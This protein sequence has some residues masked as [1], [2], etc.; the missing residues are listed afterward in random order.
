M[1]ATKSLLGILT[2]TTAL[3]VQ[4]QAQS[5]LTNGLVAYYPLNGNANDVSGNGNNGYAQNTYST[6]N[7]FGQF[8][9]A[10]GFTGNSWVYIP[11]STSMSTTNF[12]VSLMFNSQTA[13]ATLNSGTFCLLRSGAGQSSSDFYRG[14]EISA[15]DFGQNFGFWDFDGNSDYGPGKCVT[16]ISQWQ[17]NTWYNLIF[18]QNGTNAQFYVNGVLVASATNTVP[19]APAQSSP[20]YI[21]SNSS[22]T[23]DPTATPGGMFTGIIYDVRFYNRA[24]S[25]DEVHQLS[26]HESAT[27]KFELINGSF[28]S[29]DAA[30]ADAIARGGHL[31]TITSAQEWQQFVDTVGADAIT[32]NAWWLGASDI[33][34]QGVWAWIT[35]ETWSYTRWGAGEPSGTGVNGPENYLVLENDGTW[36]DAAGTIQIP[37]GYVLEFEPQGALVKQVNPAFTMLSLGANYQLQVSTDLNTWT[38][39]GG[40]FTATNS[41][42]RSTN[43][44]DV[45]SWNHLYFRLQLAP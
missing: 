15:V 5:F 33:Q 22:G 45:D 9:S 19:Y 12:T 1:K 23:S 27:P 11:Y 2:I 28:T 34:Q 39:Y 37:I 26:A 41:T 7:Q 16:P 25:S 20:F 30:N 35:G 32:S 18:T 21:G 14:Y 31:A 36:N 38:N 13:F 17:Q 8:D 6:T 24:L 10:L 29:W 43:S 3:A 4:G 42:W 40:V 44:W